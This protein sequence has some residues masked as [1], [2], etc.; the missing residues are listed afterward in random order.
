VEKEGLK[1][2]QTEGRPTEAQI[3]RTLEQS[4]PASDPPGWTL[5]RERTGG[6]A[7][8]Q[9]SGAVRA[10]LETVIVTRTRHLVGGF[11]VRRAL[12]SAKRR[13]VGPF[14]FRRCGGRGRNSSA[15]SPGSHSLVKLDERTKL[16]D[17]DIWKAP[18]FVLTVPQDSAPTGLPSLKPSKVWPLNV[19]PFVAPKAAADIRF[20]TPE[21]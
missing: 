20:T 5:G 2:D 13:M 10:S 3:D 4:F 21:L 8:K 12:P 16:R 9:Q 11:K 19:M 15:F 14:I 6:H 1:R 7:D 17:R 18:F